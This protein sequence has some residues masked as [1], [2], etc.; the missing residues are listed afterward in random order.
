MLPHRA[1]TSE[2]SSRRAMLAAVALGSSRR[3]QSS[4]LHRNQ[5]RQKASL[6][7]VSRA[8]SGATWPRHWRS[9][10]AA[11]RFRGG[12][13]LGG[14]PPRNIC[15]AVRLGRGRVRAQRLEHT[16]AQKASKDPR[17]PQAPK[18]RVGDRHRLPVPA[19][20]AQ[21]HKARRHGAAVVPDLHEHTSVARTA[22]HRTGRHDPAA[23]REQGS[24][25]S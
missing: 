9:L 5:E 21:P 8:T 2:R 23:D 25:A 18:T 3:P 11:A 17:A 16:V 20:G 1:D 19:R 22:W 4:G 12:R 10:S 13:R 15:C 6:D 24:I 14:R 7:P